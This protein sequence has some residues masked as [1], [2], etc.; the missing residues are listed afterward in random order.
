[1]FS[2]IWI[3][4]G[5]L[6]ILLVVCVVNIWQTWDTEINILPEKNS[7]GKDLSPVNLSQKRAVRIPAES[8]FNSVAGKNLFSSDRKAIAPE[9]QE[10]EP[11]REEVK[12][13]GKKVVLFGVIIMDDYKTALINNPEKRSGGIINRWVKEGDRIGNLEITHIDQQ[14]ISLNDGVNNYKVSLY[15]PDKSKKKESA[16]KQIEQPK[17][18]STGG[19]A[20]K[21][22]RKPSKRASKINQSKDVQYEY[23]DTPFGKVKRKKK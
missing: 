14:D 2:R 8:R 18:I 13:S 6:A 5:I 12:I 7:V 17:V 1:M 10:A 20:K 21:E 16:Y 23:I 15:D 4:N 3:I 22:I 19:G 11:V 9:E